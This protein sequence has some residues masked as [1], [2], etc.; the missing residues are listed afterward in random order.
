[1]SVD[2][3]FLTLGRELAKQALLDVI[4]RDHLHLRP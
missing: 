4:A 2:R 3:S 1:M